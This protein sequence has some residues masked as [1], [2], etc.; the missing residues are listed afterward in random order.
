MKKY[1]YL[2]AVSA[3]CA[4]VAKTAW[5]MGRQYEG[6][7]LEKGRALTDEEK[8]RA[9]VKELNRITTRVVD[10]KSRKKIPYES[11]D[12]FLKENPNC[13]KVEIQN[14]SYGGDSRGFDKA[15]G[16]YAGHVFVHY[17]LH[18]VDENGVA[19][20]R[21]DEFSGEIQNCGIVD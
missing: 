17:T 14:Y 18:Y 6:V 8:I 5:D 21:Q 20:R 12:S 4:F 13:C 9:V 19:R 2:L 7:C 16:V 10:G 15:M 11:V 3:I 1:L